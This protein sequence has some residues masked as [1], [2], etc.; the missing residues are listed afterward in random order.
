M[1]DDD[2]TAFTPKDWH[3]L[4]QV[5]QMVLWSKPSRCVGVWAAALM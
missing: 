5:F 1:S 3:M 2:P 4:K